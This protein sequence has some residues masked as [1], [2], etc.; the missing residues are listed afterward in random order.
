MQALNICICGS[1]SAVRYIKRMEKYLGLSIDVLDAVNKDDVA[2]YVHAV[3]SLYTQ[4]CDLS[5]LYAH[6]IILIFDIS[7]D[8][9]PFE[10]NFSILW[11]IF[12]QHVSYSMQLPY[13]IGNVVQIDVVTRQNGAQVHG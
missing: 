3:V 11:G 10:T 4:G 6:Y 5:S 1:S 2:A 9:S 13:N 8:I 12:S 7:F